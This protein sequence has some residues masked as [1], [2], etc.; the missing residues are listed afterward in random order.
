MIADPKTEENLPLINT[1][2]TDQ[3]GINKVA[4]VLSK[5]SDPRASAQ[6]RGKFFAFLHATV[7]KIRFAFLIS[8][9]TRDHGDYGDPDLTPS[10]TPSI[11]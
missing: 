8:A 2:D 6:I 4:K 1:D 9:K 5:N 3:K 11:F 10:L 7:V